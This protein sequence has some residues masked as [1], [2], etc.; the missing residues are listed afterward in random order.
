M[1][2]PFYWSLPLLSEQIWEKKWNK[3]NIKILIWN[4]AMLIQYQLFKHFSGQLEIPGNISREWKK[5]F[6]VLIKEIFKVYCKTS[7]TQELS[8]Y[9][10]SPDLLVPV[11][12]F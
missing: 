12:W 1:L 5:C 4:L 8:E 9:A 2:V 11:N 10:Y 7:H 6:T 3:Y